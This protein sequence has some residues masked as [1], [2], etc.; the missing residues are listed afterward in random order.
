MPLKQLA[1]VPNHVK[2]TREAAV[3]LLIKP[4]VEVKDPSTIQVKLSGKHA[5]DLLTFEATGSP[6]SHRRPPTKL[7]GFDL[8]INE[9]GHG[10]S[11]LGQ[12]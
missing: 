8:T 11:T 12:Q 5:D 1:Y 6:R 9:H 3:D 10:S 4:S 2:L 7:F